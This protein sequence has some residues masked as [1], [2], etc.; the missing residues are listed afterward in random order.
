MRTH[1]VTGS[2]M[3]SQYRVCWWQ[4]QLTCPIR[5]KYMQFMMS[6]V[7]AVYDVTSIC[8]LWC[9]KYMQFMMSSAVVWFP[10]HVFWSVKVSLLDKQLSANANN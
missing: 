10:Q 9:H 6:Q 5:I 3:Q 4:H 8:S 7:Y 2:R 1:N